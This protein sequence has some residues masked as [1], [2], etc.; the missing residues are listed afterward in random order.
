VPEPQRLRRNREATVLY[1]PATATFQNDPTELPEHD[2]RGRT[3]IRTT[4]RNYSTTLGWWDG[5][6]GT[7]NDDRPAHE[8]K[9]I[10]GLGHQQQFETAEY[11]FDFRMNPGFAGT[12]HF[13][14]IFQLKQTEN[15]SSG[16]PLVTVS[17][18]KNS[19]GQ[20]EGRVIADSEHKSGSDIV[21]TF[22]F[23]P[24]T[25]NH[26]VVRITPTDKLSATGGWSRRSR[27]RVQRADQRAAVVGR[28][29]RHRTASNDYRP[30]FGFYRGIGTD[31]GVPSGDSW[32]E[33]RT[34]TGYS[35]ASNALTWKG[36]AA[37]NPTVGQRRNDEFFERRGDEHLSTP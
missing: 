9:G 28:R 26:V 8:A 15:G 17:L 27:R 22:T 21:R 12:N 25:W 2:R 5:D 23:T 35:G 36:G 11:S 34:I 6:R 24:N 4:L 18:Y 31:Y 14:H 7:T 13:C 16:S 1:Y 33:H 37:G 3:M 19:S 32:I 30:K 20:T 29:R 10:D